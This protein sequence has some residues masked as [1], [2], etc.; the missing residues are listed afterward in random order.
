[1]A[2]RPWPQIGYD[3]EI[4]PQTCKK[5][6]SKSAYNKSHPYIGLVPS[7]ILNFTAILEIGCKE[8]RNDFSE[9]H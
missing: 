1:M 8:Q 2:L 9:F 4:K 3:T 6:D 7:S 5:L